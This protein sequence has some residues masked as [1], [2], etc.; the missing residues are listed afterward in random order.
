[1]A[2]FVV[3]GAVLLMGVYVGFRAVQVRSD[4][5][6]V[7]GHSTAL[8]GAI[9]G[10]DRKGADEQLKLLEASTQDAADHTGGLAW[11]LLES[12]PVLGDDAHGVRELALASVDVT[13]DGVAPLVGAADQLSAGAFTPKGKQFPMKTIAGLAEPARVA[14]TAFAAA[15]GR[16]ESVDTS[17]FSSQFKPIFDDLAGQLHETTVLLGSAAKA[18][19]LI[20]ALLGQDGPRKYLLVLQNNAE[21]RSSGGLPGTISVVRARS[22]RVEMGEQESAGT[23]LATE[24]PVLPLTSEEKAI[25]SNNLGLLFLDA[26]F[27]PDFPRAAALMRARWEV[28]T[29]DRVDGV[30]IIDPVTVSY[31]LRGTGPIKVGQATLTAQTAVDVLLNQTYV[32]LP[33]QAEQNEFFERVARKAFNVFAEGNG[34]PVGVVRALIRGVDEGRLSA[35]SA[36]PTQQ[37]V[38]G[39]SE[40]GRSLPIDDSDSPQIGVYLNDATGAKMQYYLDHQVTVESLGCRDGV[41]SMSGELTLVADTPQDIASMP[42]F[43]IGALGVDDAKKGSQLLVAHVYGPVGG[44]FTSLEVDGKRIQEPLVLDHH[45]RPVVTLELTVGPDSSVRVRWEAESGAG[46]TGDIEVAVTPGVQEGSKSSVAP[47]SC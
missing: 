11:R 21:V 15:D 7:R 46:Q 14:H 42:A 22:G 4:L 1:M 47:S 32:Y 12:L 17:G 36:D 23:L 44:R 35:W 38:L 25:F 8:S 6:E 30:F 26:N 28:E 19:D 3:L 37:E 41:Q 20:P 16:L 5:M 43:V 29:G 2:L 9:A 13:R 33:T 24:R 31:L 27:T 40:I 39:G 45:G 18:A 34:D 10:G